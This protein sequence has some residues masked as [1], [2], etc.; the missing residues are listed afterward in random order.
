MLIK[1]FVKKF[2]IFS[3]SYHL[4]KVFSVLCLGK[5]LITVNHD[6]YL[7]MRPS[8]FHKTLDFIQF[9]MTEETPREIL[10]MFL[11]RNRLMEGLPGKILK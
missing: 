1:I 4:V 3:D 8:K 11:L 5:I 9:F 10:L 2:V 6:L 7:L